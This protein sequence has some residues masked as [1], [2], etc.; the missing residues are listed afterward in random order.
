MPFNNNKGKTICR[1]QMKEA[2]LKPAYQM[3]SFYMKSRKGKT[4]ATT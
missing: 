2:S 1:I 3:I 4:V